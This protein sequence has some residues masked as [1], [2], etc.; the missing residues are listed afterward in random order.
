MQD[1][2]ADLLKGTSI[3]LFGCVLFWNLR[4]S[5]YFRKYLLSKMSPETLNKIAWGLSFFAKGIG[6]GYYL[7]ALKEF[8]KRGKLNV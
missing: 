1:Y 4:K 2:T 7:K 6:A 5:K 8:S 3:S